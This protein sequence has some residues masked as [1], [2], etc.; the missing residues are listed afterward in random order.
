MHWQQNGAPTNLF[1]N[2][3]SLKHIVNCLISKK[4]VHLAPKYLCNKVNSNLKASWVCLWSN[5]GFPIIGN[6]TFSAHQVG[7]CVCGT[8]IL[9]AGALWSLLH[10]HECF[11][12]VHKWACRGLHRISLQARCHRHH[13]LLSTQSSNMSFVN[14]TTFRWTACWWWWWQWWWSTLGAVPSI[15]LWYRPVRSNETFAKVEE[16]GAYDSVIADRTKLFF[17]QI[18]QSWFWI[19][20]RI[21]CAAQLSTNYSPFSTPIELFQ[22]S[23]NNFLQ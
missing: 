19:S 23:D 11:T 10:S 3:K 18:H 17:L 1:S 5:H 13:W 8:K 16:Y 12:N 20:H 15:W 22:C 7:F 21:Q 2:R 14:I 6:F 4:N 9:I